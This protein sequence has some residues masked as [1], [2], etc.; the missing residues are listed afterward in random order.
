MPRFRL[1]LA[2]ALLA[3]TTASGAG[4]QTTF[5]TPDEAARELAKAARAA[6]SK[7]LLAILG[8]E[9]KPILSSGDRAADK[10]ARELFVAAYE[11]AN[12]LDIS[13]EVR[14]VL[15]VGK[16]EWAFP[17]PIVKVASGWRFDASAGKEEILNRRIGRNELAAIQVAGAYV[18]AQREYYLR[19]P[20]NDRLLQYAQKLISAEG[21]RDGLYWPVK[22]GE[23]ASPLG[24]LVGGRA[25]PA[26]SKAGGKPAPYFGYYYRVLKAQ[27]PDAAGGAYSYLA[28]GRMIGGFA[29]LAWPTAYG[30]SGVMSF[31]VNHDGAVYEKDLGPDTAE[32]AGRITR[33]NPDKSWKRL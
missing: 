12:K 30:N 33:F 15:R 6:D 16:D 32:L 9:A 8:A 11:E 1:I 26:A 28:Q 19:N 13:G 20:Q 17:I 10:R 24:P 31:M 23:Q 25:G 4:A 14:V 29:L 7:A 22:A 5:A 2:A 3:A 27:G 18:D 21:R